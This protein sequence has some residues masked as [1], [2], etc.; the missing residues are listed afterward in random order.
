MA[1]GRAA[2]GDIRA[3]DATMKASEEVEWLFGV[4]CGVLLRF[5][6]RAPDFGVSVPAFG[7]GVAPCLLACPALVL[8]LSL[9]LLPDNRV[10][11]CANKRVVPPVGWAED[12]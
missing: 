5:R 9:D 2:Q 1:V 4:R 7:V 6:L 10:V 11:L 3:L 12:L 8:A